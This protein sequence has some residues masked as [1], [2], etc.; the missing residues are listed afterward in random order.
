M[1]E[2]FYNPLPQKDMKFL[3]DCPFRKPYQPAATTTCACGKDHAPKS[4]MACGKVE[5]FAGLPQP[6]AP[7]NCAQCVLEKGEP[8]PFYIRALARPMLLGQVQLCLFGFFDDPERIK[9]I[10]KRA[11]EV[12]AEDV[13][14][15]KLIA[16]FL[17][18]CVKKGR[19]SREQA[20]DLIQNHVP[21]L[22]EVDL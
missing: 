16:D 7:T 10:F 15:R 17:E 3:A 13:N 2:L 18:K 8:S 6:V 4:A 9:G 11:W 20:A 12:L 1:P 21:G 19:L 14:Q 22:G 5:E